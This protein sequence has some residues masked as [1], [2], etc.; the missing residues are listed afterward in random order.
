[1]ASDG[2]SVWK[3]VK[4]LGVVVGYMLIKNYTLDRLT[5]HSKIC[6]VDFGKSGFGYWV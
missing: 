3:T 1:M 5:L 6:N 4:G 2:K